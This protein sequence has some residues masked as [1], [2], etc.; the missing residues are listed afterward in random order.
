MR[1]NPNTSLEAYYNRIVDTGARET[2]YKKI[3]DALK[4]IGEGN[5]ELIAAAANEKES[6]I[7]KRIGELRKDGLVIDTGKRMQ[8][9]DNNAS[10][11]YALFM[12]AEKYKD[13]AKPE[14]FKKNQTTAADFANMIIAK[15]SKPLVQK[16]LF[17]K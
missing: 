7:W 10:M 6:R 5:Y 16:E 4:K 11:V 14:G 13:V 9:K 12:D 8:T 3:L 2:T 1:K 17:E 15:N